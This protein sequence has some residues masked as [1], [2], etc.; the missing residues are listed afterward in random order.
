MSIS[1]PLVSFIIPY[2]NAGETIQENIDSI[3]NQTYENFDVWIVNDGSTDPY[4][5]EKLKDFEGDERIKILHQENTGP[6]VA[7]NLAIEKTNADYFVPLDAD[8]LI[9]HNAL[10]SAIGLIIH[11][12]N[13]GAVYGNFDWFGGIQGTKKQAEF[14][15]EKQFLMNQIAVTA[16]IRKEMWRELNGY[17]I[18]LSKPGLEDWEFWLK[19][20]LSNWSLNHLDFSF[21]KVRVN[22]ASRTFEVANKNLD[23]IKKFVYEKHAVA[24]AQAY[25]TLWYQKKQLAETPD[26]RIGNFL[27]SPYRL[28]KRIFFVK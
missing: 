9:E 28:L 13:I 7:R 22:Q 21:F 1:N 5:I 15:M 23:M 18:F 26:Y 3:F 12:C 20:G 27:M 6:S 25:E 19:A 2:F 4:S 16:L 8:D 17:D 14:Q 10:E 11:N 24:L